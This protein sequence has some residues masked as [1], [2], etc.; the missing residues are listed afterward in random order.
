MAVKQQRGNKAKIVP[1]QFKPGQSGNPD[2]RPVG[3]RDR[4]TVAKEIFELVAKYPAKKYNIIKKIFEALPQEMSAEHMMFM[5]CVARVIA[6]GDAHAFDKLM[7]ARYGKQ[8]ASIEIQD[9]TEQ[10]EYIQ[11]VISKDDL[12]SDPIR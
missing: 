3:S 5:S 1:Y 2:G 9:M 12:K 10:P 4:S 7:D 8:R 6:T 11:F